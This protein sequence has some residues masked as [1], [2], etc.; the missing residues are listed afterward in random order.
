MD[1][2]I[3]S[4]FCLNK[5]NENKPHYL[6][7]FFLRARLLLDTLD[8]LGLL[9]KLL[10]GLLLVGRKVEGQGASLKKKN[11]PIAIPGLGP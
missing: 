5:R 7:S 9:V 10:F 3:I 11:K 1:L 4:I 8:I 6:R 2:K